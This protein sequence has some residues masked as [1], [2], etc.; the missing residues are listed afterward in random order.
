MPPA[1]ST[2]APAV[3]LLSATY[4]GHDQAAHD[5]VLD[6]T[7]PYDLAVFLAALHAGTLAAR[8]DCATRLRAYGLAAAEKER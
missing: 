1:P 8:P 7:N 5:A 6:S 2:A 3:A 4:G